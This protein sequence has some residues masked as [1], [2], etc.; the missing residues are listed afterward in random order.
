MCEGALVGD[1][2]TILPPSQNMTTY[3]CEYLYEPAADDNFDGKTLALFFKNVVIGSKTTIHCR[4]SSSRI[5]VSVGKQL[6]KDLVIKKVPSNNKTDYELFDFSDQ[7]GGFRDLC[8]N[9]TKLEVVTSPF[10]RTTVKVITILF[11]KFY[12]LFIVFLSL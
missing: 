2:G 10:R 4:F 6:N 1:E 7:V 12:Y 5:S 3:Y 8:G 9:Y 11:I